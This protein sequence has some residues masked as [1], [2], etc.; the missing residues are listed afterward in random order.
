MQRRNFLKDLT[1]AG[2]LSML[3]PNYLA[4]KETLQSSDHTGGHVPKRR[5]GRAEDM[6]SIIGFGGI[7]GLMG[8]AFGM[9]GFLRD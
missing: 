6:V 3:D 1:A 4:A 9:W 2:L 8:S 7:T 5:F